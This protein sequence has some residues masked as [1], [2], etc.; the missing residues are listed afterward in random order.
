MLQYN[1]KQHCE[2]ESPDQTLWSTAC[3]PKGVFRNVCGLD[4]YRV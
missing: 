4:A 3:P 2:L 1:K